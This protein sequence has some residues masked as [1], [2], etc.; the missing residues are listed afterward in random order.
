VLPDRSNRRGPLPALFLALLVLVLV[1][2]APARG[3]RRARDPVREWARGPVRYLMTRGEAKLWRKLKTREERI[4]FIRRFWERRDPVPETPENEFRLLFWHRVREANRLFDDTPLPGWKTDRGKIYILLGPPTDIERDENYDHRE[5]GT[6][7]RGLLRWVYHGL[8]RAANSAYYVVAFVRT[9]DGDWHL[10]REPR[11]NTPYFD[12]TDPFPRRQDPDTAWARL[13]EL[14]P[15]EDGNLGIA[16]DL[17]ALQ[18]IPSERELMRRVVEAEQFLG[19]CRGAISFHP[20][21]TGDGRHLVAITL[22]IR[23]ED[24]VPPWDGTA[25]GLADR[26]AASAM[27]RPAKGNPGGAIEVPDEAFVG[28]PAPDPSAPWLLFQAIRAVPPGAWEVTGVILDR[29]GG[30]AATATGH[31]EVPPPGPGT[32]AVTGP[33]LCRFLARAPAPETSA[34]WPFRWGEVVYVPRVERV[35]G[36]RDPFRL[37]LGVAGPAGTDDVPVGLDWSFERRATPGGTWSPWG[38]PGHLDDARGPRA[39]DLPAGSLPPGEWRIR[40]LARAGSGGTPLERTVLFTVKDTDEREPPPA[41]LGPIAPVRHP[42][43]VPP[44]PEPAPMVGGGDDR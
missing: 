12:I 6:V 39:W 18:E 36:P 11:F 35:L 24:L 32:P 30:G 8:R 19:T 10:T 34:T 5:E 40:F 16:M 20:V 26:F 22:A 4:A 13:F 23:R 17:A 42:V 37:F 31:L 3:K 1:A 43:P 27:L 41:T 33:V 9:G 7:G 44:L 38:R 21:T 28:E 14:V 25:T 29:R 15:W 2:P